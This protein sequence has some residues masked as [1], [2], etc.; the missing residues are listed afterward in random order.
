MTELPIILLVLAAA[1]YFLKQRPRWR[2]LSRRWVA[3]LVDREE[4]IAE[5]EQQLAAY[6]AAVLEHAA[7][8]EW[9]RQVRIELG[10]EKPT[11]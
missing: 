7:A 6:D 1:W 11:A 5:L 4:R 9:A 10:L 2:D 3:T 8:A